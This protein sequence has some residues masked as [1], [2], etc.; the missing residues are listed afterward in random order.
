MR[1]FTSES[2]YNVKTGQWEER[3]WIDGKSVDADEYF[4]QQ[5]REKKLESDKL[6]KQIELEDDIDEIDPCENCKCRDCCE[7]EDNE[8]FDYEDLLD[9]FV[10]RILDTEGCPM[11]IRDILDEAISIF[12][13]DEEN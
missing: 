11:C 13:P 3:F 4:F 5:D 8:G 7:A 9:V 12:I 10:G 1:L 6:L 2:I